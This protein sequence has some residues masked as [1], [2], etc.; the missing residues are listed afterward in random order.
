MPATNAGMTEFL[1]TAAR[2]IR[3]DIE[4]LPLVMA[5]LVTAIQ[6]NARHTPAAP[7]NC[8]RALRPTAHAIT[9]ASYILNT[10]NR[11][12]G[13]GA[14][15]VAERARATTRRVSAGAMMPSSHRRAVA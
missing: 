7:T 5:V 10:P 6:S 8:W 12:S 1:V 11:M 15:R 13:I 2:R 3:S 4:P 9:A 14:L